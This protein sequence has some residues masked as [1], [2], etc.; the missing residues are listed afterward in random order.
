MKKNFKITSLTAATLASV[1]LASANLNNNAKAADTAQ[2]EKAETAKKV[3]SPEDQA[4]ANVKSAQK[5]VDVAQKN[6]DSS[7]A[8]LE[9]AKSEAVK[10]DQAYKDQEAKKAAA[11]KN[12]ENKKNARDDA[13]KKQADA[14][15]LADEATPDAIAKAKQA[16]DA[17]NSEIAQKQ[18]AVK[19][20]QAKQ[21]AAQK[22]IVDANADVQAKKAALTKAENAKSEADVQVNNTQDALN[23]TGV[24]EVS[25]ELNSVN[26]IVEEDN[27]ELSKANNIVTNSEKSKQQADTELNNAKSAKNAANNDLEK[28]KAA[29]DVAAQKS[30]N[31]NNALADKNREVEGLINKLNSFKETSVN[32]IKITDMDKYQKALKDYFILGRLTQ[33]DIDYM[34]E[35]RSQNQYKSSATAKKEKVDLNNLTDNQKQ[36]LSLFA[37]DITNKLRAQFGWKPASVVKGSLQ[38]A[39]NVARQYND[40]NKTNH[41]LDWHDENALSNNAKQMN[42]DRYSEAMDGD[43]FDGSITNMDDLKKSI[44]NMFLHM[45]YTD[46]HGV[47]EKGGKSG[48]ELGHAAV[49]LNGKMLIPNTSTGSNPYFASLDDIDTQPL[50]LQ[51][52]SYKNDLISWKKIGF[53]PTKETLD[54]IKADIADLQKQIDEAKPDNVAFSI[55]TLGGGTNGKVQYHFLRSAS[56]TENNSK[57]NDTVIP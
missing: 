42:V 44:Y 23:G 30:T 35:A 24:N 38:F 2:G 29:N 15:K 7:K 14:Q 22:A 8:D 41:F 48:Y 12:A 13:A 28:T 19:D 33:D 49:L 55:D 4:K 37:A 57:Y 54:K 27:K 52:Q 36:D 17:K 6:V 16:V 11:D 50:K 53:E 43:N 1:V 10:P 32:T 45:I 34:N 21:G 39:D 9:K 5:E 56:S 20:A 51:I 47:T 26:T 31:A 18:Q 46:G 3:Q 25:K 40:D